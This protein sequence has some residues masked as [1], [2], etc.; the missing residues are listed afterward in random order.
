MKQLRISKAALFAATWLFFWVASPVRAEDTY[1]V[2]VPTEYKN[3][4][5]KRH[6]ALRLEY[7]RVDAENLAAPAESADIKNLVLYINDEN[8]E[9]DA[10]KRIRNVVEK[11]PNKSIE[12]R[13]V[14]TK[15]P[16]SLRAVIAK[17]R[18]ENKGLSLRTTWTLSSKEDNNFIENMAR[19]KAAL[20][21]GE[22]G[23]QLQ[24]AGIDPSPEGVASAIGL[25]SGDVL[26]NYYATKHETEIGKAFS[27]H[28]LPV[29]DWEYLKPVKEYYKNSPVAR[30]AK[31][32]V[33]NIVVWGLA[34]NSAFQTMSHGASPHSARAVSGEDVER[35]LESSVIGSLVYAASF[36]GIEKWRQKGWISQQYLDRYLR[37]NNYLYQLASVA[38]TSGNP[39][40]IAWFNTLLY[41]YWGVYAVPAVLGNILPSRTGRLVIVDDTIKDIKTI[42]DFEGLDSTAKVTEAGS[43]KK[44]NVKSHDD[45]KELDE[46]GLKSLPQVNSRT[47][48]RILGAVDKVCG[49]FFKKMALAE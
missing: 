21:V 44:Y 27:D 33:A 18:S 3:P 1:T 16:S 40:L 8:P 25:V 2:F 24:Q 9:S 30:F 34:T 35:F 48:N 46:S 29:P 41:S 32:T 22:R 14:G 31:E 43:D 47:G 19:I 11:F 39:H 17:I 26:L 23:F 42:R 37:S 28:S 12:V 45:S 38:N 5:P 36:D 10:E 20:A 7:E 15:P 13:L 4:L 6:D 49:L